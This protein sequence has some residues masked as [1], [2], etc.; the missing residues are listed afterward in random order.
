MKNWKKTH[1]LTITV[2]SRGDYSKTPV[3]LVFENNSVQVLHTKEEWEAGLTASYEIRKNNLYCEG[4]LVI[5]S[6]ELKEV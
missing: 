2:N 3:M 4:Q 6:W 1:T 5:G